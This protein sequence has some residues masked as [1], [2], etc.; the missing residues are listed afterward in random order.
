MRKALIAVAA[1]ILIFTH[2]IPPSNYIFATEEMDECEQMAFTAK[3]IKENDLTINGTAGPSQNIEIEFETKNKRELVST[4]DNGEFSLDIEDELLESNDVITIS[5]DYFI[6]ETVVMPV[7]SEDTSIQSTQYV[8]CP[9]SA[10]SIEEPADNETTNEERNP[11]ESPDMEST[12]TDKEQ[13]SEEDLSNIEDAATTFENESQ[14]I[15][16]EFESD[17]HNISENNNP[18]SITPFASLSEVQLLTDVVIDATLTPDNERP[19]EDQLYN[20]NLN[21]NG[22]GLADVELASPNRVAVFHAPDLA[23]E[24][25]HSGG[26]ATVQVDILPLTMNDLPVLNTAL[27]GLQGSLTGLV[28]GLLTGIDAALPL[29]I[30]PSLVEVNGI[31]EL[32]AAIDNLNNLNTALGDVSSYTDN[33]EYIVNADGTIVVDFS[34]GLGNHLETAVIDIAQAAL[35]DVNDAVNNLEINILSWLPIVGDL[36]SSL[37][38]DLLIPLVGEVIGLVNT[39]GTNLTNGVIDLTNDLASAQV[40][41]NTNVN[42]DVSV[43]NPPGDV[44]G[45]VPVLGAGIQDSVIDLALLNSLQSQDTI[46]FPNIAPILNSA[47][48]EGNSTDGYRITGTGEEPGD[49]VNVTNETGTVVGTGVI[50]ENGTYS[51]T[52]EGDVN[53]DEVLTVQAVD[54]AGNKSNTL[55]VTVPLDVTRIESVPDIV[56]NTTTITDE[57]TLVLRQSENNSVQIMDTRRDGEWTLSAGAN[58][59]NNNNGEILSNALIY[60][61]RNGEE[62]PLENGAVPVA[63]SEDASSSELIDTITWSD[64]EGMLLR[65]NPIFAQAGTTYNSTITW[66]LNDAPQ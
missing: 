57:E 41:G 31:D 47:N 4:D 36:L 12:E 60:I 18:G 52:L 9:V 62:V 50:E 5:N 44:E 28:T 46:A 1:F 13:L 3:N 45:T 7:E 16:K 21:L 23:G 8:E 24:L 6:I 10:D 33:V 22:K 35:N 11:E 56:F 15:I 51:F 42:L 26:T 17:I 61:K 63:S 32:N 59:L 14:L 65:L 66:T 43:N 19:P 48:I 55:K 20:L 39:L 30:P 25:V 40:I 53:P 54:E 2:V 37:T 49:T 29:L 27:E 38:N 58:S 34:D 64:N